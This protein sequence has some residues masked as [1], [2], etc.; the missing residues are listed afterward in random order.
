MPP[1]GAEAQDNP[2]WTRAEA[3]PSVNFV[4]AAM[5]ETGDIV[6]AALGDE[7]RRALRTEGAAMSMDEAINFAL[8]N[9]D[10]KL[11]TGPV[12]SIDR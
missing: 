9:I 6:A 12:A 5:H 4:L 7:R 11:R 1:T 2:C 10:P 3:I 8:A